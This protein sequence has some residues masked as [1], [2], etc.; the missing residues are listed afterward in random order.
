MNPAKLND[1]KKELL[2]LDSKA[3]VE[4][5]L[6]VVK[7]KK[8][9]KELVNYLLFNAEEPLEYAE[10]VKSSLLEEFENLPKHYYYS[11]KSLRKV[12]RAMNKHIKYTGSKEVEIEITIWFCDNFLRYTDT[13]SGQKPLRAILVRQ[14]ERISKVL[15]KLHEDLQ[16]DYHLEFDKLQ[17]IAAVKMKNEKLLNFL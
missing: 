4:I 13:K 17:E 15:P 11:I 2:N 8:E 12:L 10:L 1:L 7:Y 16:F 9:N 5:C 14:M 3:L 6:R